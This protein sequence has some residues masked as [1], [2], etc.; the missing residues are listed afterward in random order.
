MSVDEAAEPSRTGAGEGPRFL[1]IKDV[2]EELSVGEPS[3][4]NLIKT[5][6]LP[7]I[8]IGR[9][10]IWRVE[11]TV[12]ENYIAAQYVRAEADR[13]ELEETETDDT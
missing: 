13:A 12:L 10:G 7:A 8:Q 5:G 3:V 1:S 11:R 4:R 9:R 6:S 2:A